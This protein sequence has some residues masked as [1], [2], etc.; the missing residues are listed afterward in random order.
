[1][2]KDAS[3]GQQQL[4]SFACD[5]SMSL[6]TLHASGTGLLFADHRFDLPTNTAMARVLRSRGRK[7]EAEDELQQEGLV[8]PVEP[9]LRTQPQGDSDDDA[10][11][12]VT[13]ATGRAQADER[14]RQERST[15]AAQQESVRRKRQQQHEA[16]AARKRAREAVAKEAQQEPLQQDRKWQE[17][18]ATDPA[19]L[20]YALP[21]SED[22]LPTELLKELANQSKYVAPC[23]R[24]VACSAFAVHRLRSSWHTDPAG[25]LMLLLRAPSL[26]QV[27]TADALNSS[28]QA[29]AAGKKKKKKAAKQEFKK[30]PMIVKTLKAVEEQAAGRSTTSLVQDASAVRMFCWTHACDGPAAGTVRAT[31]PRTPCC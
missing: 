23:S 1:V 5:L 3:D 27:S 31:L 13:L 8:E 4:A 9:Q 11:E 15:V 17:G 14:R 10:P 26:P 22:L 28:L 24:I 18:A 30:G 21:P 6:I 20:G 2:T 7:R 12:E 16:A 19:A 25:A 29:A